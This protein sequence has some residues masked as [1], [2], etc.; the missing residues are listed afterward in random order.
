[1]IPAKYHLNIRISCQI[2]DISSIVFRSYETLLVGNVPAL[3]AVGGFRSCYLSPD[4]TLS[5]ENMLNYAL[6]PPM[7]Y[8]VCCAP[9]FFFTSQL[10]LKSIWSGFLLH[11][12]LF[13]AYIGRKRFCCRVDSDLISTLFPMLIILKIPFVF[14][15]FL[16]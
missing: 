4:K 10:V 14:A 15:R 16:L 11:C 5:R 13:L 9:F 6:I 8:S 3:C 7:A 1:M 12:L 2:S